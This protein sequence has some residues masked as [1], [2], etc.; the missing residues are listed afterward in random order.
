MTEN[1]IKQRILVVDDIGQNISVANEILKS[2]YTIMVALNGQKALS[3]ANSDTPPD[4]ILLD[5]MMPEMDGFEVCKRLKSDPKTHDIPIIFLSSLDDTKDKVKGLELGA[6]DYILK[7]FQPEEVI[8]RVK[9]HLTISSLKISLAEKNEELKASN[10][11]L[12]ERVKDRTAELVELNSVYERFVPREFLELLNR[13]SILDIKLGDQINK[14]MT[15]M[16]ADVRGWTTLSESLTPQENFKFINA[17]LRRVSPVIKEHNGFIDQYYGDG[18][19]ALFQ[20]SPDD[21]LRA[22]IAMHRAVNEYNKEREQEGFKP[23]GIGVGLHVGDLMLGII[24]SKERMQ[25]AV[26]ADAVNL[27]ARLEGLTRV[28]GSTITISEPTLSRLKNPDRYKHR[29]VD[30]VQ[31]KGRD[32]AVSVYEVFDGDPQSVMELKEQT[33]GIFEEGLRLY[34]EK[35][36]SESSVQFNRVLETNPEDKAARIYLKRSANYMVKGVPDDWTGVERN[37]GVTS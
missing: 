19:M 14:E 6:V 3:I 18:V 30:R 34:Y 25:G 8:A 33:K 23:I 13:E 15:V 10:D 27:A 1:G 22:A 36:F 24:G 7:P 26:V 2:Y 37:N 11:Y 28:Y 20:G 5:I 32:E 35:K 4:L 9:T 16:F 12:E 29:F 17:Y 21:A 31:V